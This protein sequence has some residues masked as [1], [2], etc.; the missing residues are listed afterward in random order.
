[1]FTSM[2]RNAEGNDSERRQRHL[3]DHL[4]LR[5]GEHH[6]GFCSGVAI[7]RKTAASPSWRT[8]N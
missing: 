4:L 3:L 7:F 5:P 1:M 6:V 2:S 8:A